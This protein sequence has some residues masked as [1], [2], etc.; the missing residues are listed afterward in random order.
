MTQLVIL[1]LEEA[2]ERGVVTDE[3]VTQEKLEG[4]LSKFGRQFYQ[5][6]EASR[7][8]TLERRGEKI[9]TSM[10]NEDGSIE[11]GISKAGADVFSLGWA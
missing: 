3:D 8:I 2:I 10:R 5:L 9:P 11:V 7:K 1:A 6:P 4:F